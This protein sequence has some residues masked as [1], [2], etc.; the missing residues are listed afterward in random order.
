[1]GYHADSSATARWLVAAD[2]LVRITREEG[3]SYLGKVV[4][5][6]LLTIAVWAAHEGLHALP[7]LFRVIVRWVKGG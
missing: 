4:V 6:I 1:M 3:M 5:A 2:I 7:K